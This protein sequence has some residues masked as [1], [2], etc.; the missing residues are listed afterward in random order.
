MLSICFLPP[1]LL[2][3]IFYPSKWS[4]SDKSN[5]ALWFTHQRARNILPIQECPLLM[6]RLCF[7]CLFSPHSDSSVHCKLQCRK[8]PWPLLLE[9][10][11]WN[12]CLQCVWFWCF[13][14]PGRSIRWRFQNSVSHSWVFRLSLFSF[15]RFE[16]ITK[17]R[18]FHQ[19]F[20]CE[21]T[22]YLHIPFTIGPIRSVR[23]FFCNPLAIEF[24]SFIV[25]VGWVFDWPGLFWSEFPSNNRTTYVLESI[26]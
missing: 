17:G 10:R 1:Y 8:C 15:R 21:C 18:S 12:V 24:F 3:Y 6:N 19:L 26:Y 16:T 11:Y 23:E 7:L 2:F 13:W 25:H 4:G 22:Q 14:V 9:G 20:W 5:K